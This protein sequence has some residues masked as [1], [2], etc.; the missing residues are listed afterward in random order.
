MGIWSSETCM[1]KQQNID[2]KNFFNFIAK[3]MCC[4]ARKKEVILSKKN[5]R[6]ETCTYHQKARE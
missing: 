1:L 6:E 4:A 5:T 3:H 2:L